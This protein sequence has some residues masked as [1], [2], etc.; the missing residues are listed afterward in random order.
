[1]YKKSI[2]ETTSKLVNLQ[3]GKINSEFVSIV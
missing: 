2:T 3:N 1:M